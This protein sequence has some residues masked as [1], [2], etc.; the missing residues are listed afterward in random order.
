MKS[1]FSTTTTTC[2]SSST[3]AAPSTTAT[4]ATSGNGSKEDAGDTSKKGRR[5]RR[6][7][8]RPKVDDDDDDFDDIDNNT[9]LQQELKELAP[10]AYRA[11]LAAK[12]YARERCILP[13]RIGS[14]L[15]DGYRSWRRYG[16]WN[17][18]GMTWE[19]I[20]NQYEDQVLREVQAGA[21]VDGLL[22]GGGRVDDA[23][24]AIANNGDSLREDEELT[25]R[26]CLRIL[27]RSVVTNEAIDRLF[28]KSIAV[29]DVSKVGSI[30]S[31]STAT[32]GTR[33]DEKRKRQ[34]RQQQQ[35]RRRKLVRQLRRKLQIQADLQAIEKKFDDDIRE[36]L[37][38][39]NLASKEGEERRSSRRGGAFFWKK[40]IE[41][42]RDVDSDI[43]VPGTPIKINGA[44]STGDVDMDA[45]LIDA[46][47]KDADEIQRTSSADFALRGGTAD[48]NVLGSTSSADV[49]ATNTYS[50]SETTIT[51]NLAESETDTE[52]QRE[53]II[54]MDDETQSSSVR[55]LAVHE[56]IALR[57]LAMT[58][59]RIASLQASPQLGGDGPE[60]TDTKI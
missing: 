57:I 40:S 54:N 39:S 2:S 50:M 41:S 42:G 46:L 48:N 28:L 33:G 43:A 26:I 47:E 1:S 35:Q 59:Q 58:K 37:R 30:S 23:A 44:T 17:R 31:S 32:D 34:R 15:Y 52:Q 6:S 7:W 29:E 10:L 45:S 13:A 24:D 8:R 36:L 4:T 27:E 21:K 11:R 19:Q 12:E 3:S 20:W 49:D 38:F 51:M 5:Q 55:K 9:Y 16:K 53:S 22:E 14:M 18:S 60:E 25:A 56:V